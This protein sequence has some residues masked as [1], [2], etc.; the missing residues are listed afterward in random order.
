MTGNITEREVTDDVIDARSGVANNAEKPVRLRWWRGVPIVVWAVTGLHVALMLMATVLYPPFSGYDETWHVDMTW[1]YYKG[2]GVF[3]PGER[4]L[5]HGIEVATESVETPPPSTPFAQSPV[6]PRGERGSLD[7][8]GGN[9]TTAYPVPNQMVQHPPLFYVLQAGLLH[10]LPGAGD[11]PYDQLVWL[12]R[13]FNVV[14]LAPLPILCWATARRFQEHGPAAVLAAIIPVT[15]PGLIRLGGSVNNDNLLVLLYS[16]LLYLLARVVTG[17]L[18]RRTGA[19]VGVVAALALMT[20]GFA[21]TQ[22]VVIAAAYGVAWL[23]HRRRPLA[24]LGI[25]AVIVVAFGSVWWIRNLVLYGAVQ[26]S[27]LG[28]FW[29]RQVEGPARP[30]GTLTDFVPGFARL[31]ASRL[32]GGI[33]LIDQPR[34]PGPVVYGWFAIVL[35]GA[36]IGVM[37]GVGRDRGWPARLSAAVFVLP[38]VG[39]TAIVFAGAL[40]RYMHD[41]QFAGVQG[42][43]LYGGIVGIAALA[44]LGWSR[45]AGRWA[46]LLPPVVLTVGILTQAGA[47]LLL[48]RDWWSPRGNGSVTRRLLE[49]FGGI[50]RWSPWPDAVTVVPFVLAGATAVALLGLT[51]WSARH[52]SA[53]EPVAEAVAEPV[54]SS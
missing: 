52:A 18:S 40:S 10:A 39:I 27:G 47:W 38:V 4:R 8:L 26:P 13:L 15:I 32:W 11:L 19:L 30:G 3:G 48:V 34:L 24:P 7:E 29:T 12:L 46:R 28:P 54:G 44:A 35:V 31:L 51:L 33:G 16:V 43:Y 20:K 37:Y 21:L 36:V 42:R 22:P 41:Q 50:R 25:T 5:D 45:L 17:D 2:D 49:G 23:R 53:A 1:S 6:P 9:G 14:M